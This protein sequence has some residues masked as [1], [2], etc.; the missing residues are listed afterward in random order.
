MS[1]WRINGDPAQTNITTK[2]L[3]IRKFIKRDSTTGI[4]L[5]ILRNFYRTAFLYNSPGDLF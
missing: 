4:L 5:W 3:D 1:V 2:K